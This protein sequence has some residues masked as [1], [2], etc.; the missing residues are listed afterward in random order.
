MHRKTSHHP[1]LLRR[2]AAGLVF[3]LVLITVSPVVAEQPSVDPGA[4]S[5]PVEAPATA[6]W[7]AYI[8]PETGEL[9]SDPSPLQVKALSDR[10]EPALSHSSEGLESFELQL[11]G[12]GV[13]L[14][15][16]FQSA[17]RVQVVDD[18]GYEMGCAEAGHAD[19]GDSTSVHE[20]A[21]EQ[22]MP[23]PPVSTTVQWVER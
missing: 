13:F 22:P 1:T 6:G 15:E 8:D 21:S 23:A 3:S 12:R 4:T 16:R 17:L 11:G 20:H 5:E 18:G 7:R 14:Q 9:T 10:L 19:A 2:P